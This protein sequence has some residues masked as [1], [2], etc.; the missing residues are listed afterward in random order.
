MNRKNG[1]EV[2]GERGGGF[3]RGSITSPEYQGRLG[4]KTSEKEL[5][6]AITLSQA[7]PIG[8]LTLG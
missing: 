8:S 4:G 5:P 1:L 7:F 2:M 3:P 6:M